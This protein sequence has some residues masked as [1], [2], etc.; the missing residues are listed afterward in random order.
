MR[1]TE[2][3][4]REN[5]KKALEKL[6]WRGEQIEHLQKRVRYYERWLT[7]INIVVTNTP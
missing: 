1:L 3:W 2:K 4:I 6:K 7:R 5:P